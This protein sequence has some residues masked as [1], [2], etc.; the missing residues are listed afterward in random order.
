MHITHGLRRASLT[1]HHQKALLCGDRVLT[2]G[3][4]ENRTARF[5]AALRD[6]GVDSDNRVALL[7]LN[8]IH[9]FEFFFG[10]PWAGGIVV[11]V[12]TRL[13]AIEMAHV[14]QNAGVE[15]LLV[16]E[17]FV[18][19]ARE[20]KTLV[21]EIRHWI[22]L[23]ADREGF[24]S[25]EALL[26]Q[27]A[28]MED[29]LRG[30]G[31]IAAI[32]YT[33]G[34]T[35]LP[36]GVCL[37]HDNMASNTMVSLYNMGFDEDTI[38]LH[39][40]PLFHLAG[41]G[42]IYTTVMARCFGI[43]LPSFDPEQVLAAIETHRVT[44]LLLVP[45][46]I[47]MVMNLDCFFDYDLGSLTNITYG[48]SIMPEP[49]LR[50]AMERLPHVRFQQSYGM[51]ELSPA[52]TLLGPKY[53]VLDGPHAGKLASCG[54]PICNADIRIVDEQ[55]REVPRYQVGEITVRGPMVMK[56]YWNN[57]EETEKA[58]RNGWMHT[59]D[60]GYMDEDGFIY[61]VDRVK[62]MI[63]SGGENI[64]SAEVEN[65][66]YQD[67][68]VKECAVIGIPSEEWGESVHAI[69]V[70]KPGTGIDPQE[71]VDHCRKQIAGY[72]IPRSVEVRNE[73]LPLSGA[74]K[75][76]KSELRA[77]FWKGRDKAVS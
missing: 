48:A 46:M 8:G 24:L 13:A 61:I 59:G 42:R 14:L 36:K 16:D 38:Y 31:D 73:P 17:H 26:E 44:H 50:L 54:E 68:R 71:I 63:I 39:T 7:A 27:S 66:I 21:P 65:A 49:V 72:K 55:D 74:N 56:G 3:Q 9:F 75:I 41:G 25:Y 32:I 47:N 51:T 62:D 57:P 53:H 34:T 28:P 40:A 22:V 2:W 77:P 19:R 67:V 20:L 35:G 18:E 70:P 15:V 30:G 29:R 5:A 1:R 64:Y 43:I 11:P 4:L 52:A 10:V 37:T 12:N 23:G 60:A 45:T 58:L 69:V 76:L 6:L 33:G